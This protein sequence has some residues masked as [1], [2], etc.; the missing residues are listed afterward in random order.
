[1]TAAAIE[2]A[3]ALV[4]YLASLG[5]SAVRAYRPAYEMEA[6]A[7]E[8]REKPKVTVIPTARTLQLVSRT[9]GASDE[10]Q[11]GIVVQRVCE[12]EAQRDATVEAA[13]GIALAILGAKLPGFPAAR[14]TRIDNSPLFDPDDL[15]DF[16]V[17]TVPLVCTFHLAFETP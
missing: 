12:D 6:L 13:D 3:D 14:C 10:Q 2:L 5:H 8:T 17:L 7:I 15:D 11:T 4:A 1:M 16:R 9:R